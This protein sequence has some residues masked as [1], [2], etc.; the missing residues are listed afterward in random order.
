MKTTTSDILPGVASRIELIIR[1]ADWARSNDMLPAPADIRR[2]FRVSRATSYRWH[3]ALRE[4]RGRA[5]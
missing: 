5:R 4:A 3:Q 1:L 2:K